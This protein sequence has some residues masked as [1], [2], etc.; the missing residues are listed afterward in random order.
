LRLARE[1]AGD[2]QANAAGGAGYKC[3][4]PRS[5]SRFSLHSPIVAIFVAAAAFARRGAATVAP[6]MQCAALAQVAGH[7]VLAISA[8][9]LSPP[10]S[11]ASCHVAALSMS[12]SGPDFH[13]A[14]QAEER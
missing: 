10:S 12:M 3:G 1:R 4:L 9:R 13:A 7:G 5:I 8:T 2:C 11:R 6:I 14:V